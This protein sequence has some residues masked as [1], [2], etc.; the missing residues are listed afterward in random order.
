MFGGLMQLVAYG[1]IDLYLSNPEN[2]EIWGLYECLECESEFDHD[3]IHNAKKCPNCGIDIA[4][5][6]NAC[7]GTTI[8]DVIEKMNKKVFTE[9]TNI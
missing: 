4:F 9:D 1:A 6:V 8:E 7:S 3:K 2:D 5:V